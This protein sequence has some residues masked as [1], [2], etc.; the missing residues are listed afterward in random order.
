MSFLLGACCSKKA[1]TKKKL[2]QTRE[3][4][5]RVT[6]RHLRFSNEQLY[7]FTKRFEAQ[8][9]D[10]KM[11]LKQYRDSLGLIGM[12]SLSYMA[13]RMFSVMDQDKNGYVS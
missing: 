1:P 5:E 7:E 6:K 3:E 10:H 2:Q 4:I 11:N 12:Q 8:A 9:L 13:D